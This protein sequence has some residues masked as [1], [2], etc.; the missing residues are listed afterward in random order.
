MKKMNLIVIVGALTFIFSYQSAIGFDWVHVINIEM[1]GGITAPL[2][3]D[4]SSITKEG[5]F[6]RVLVSAEYDKPA[7]DNRISEKANWE[8]DCPAKKYRS[9]KLIYNYENGDLITIDEDSPWRY[10][11]PMTIAEHIY[12]TVC[13]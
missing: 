9:L 2:Y 12:K 10:I 6:I 8:F 3:F 5:K 13:P 11:I 7:S 4:K 1:T